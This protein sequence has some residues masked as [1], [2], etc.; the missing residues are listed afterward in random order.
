[1]LRCELPG[2]GYRSQVSGN[3]FQGETK[4]AGLRSRQLTKV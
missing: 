3:K 2:A 1:M 4:V